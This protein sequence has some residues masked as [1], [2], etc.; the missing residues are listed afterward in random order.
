MD[1]LAEVQKDSRGFM[2][3]TT[4]TKLK[5]LSCRRE[6]HIWRI[7]AREKYTEFEDSN[8]EFG[9]GALV[10]FKVNAEG[11]LDGSIKTAHPEI[12]KILQHFSELKREN[13]SLAVR[14]EE[15]K[16]S[17]Q[18]EKDKLS[19]RESSIIN[20]YDKLGE[21]E[22]ELNQF[23]KEYSQLVGAVEQESKREAL[24]DS[25]I[26]KLA[27]EEA[28]IIQQLRDVE[29]NLKRG[30]CLEKAEVFE[31]EELID[32]LAEEIGLAD[33]DALMKLTN[34]KIASIEIA[35]SIKNKF[36][37]LEESNRLLSEVSMQQNYRSDIAS[38]LQERSELEKLENLPLEE[39]KE[40]TN[41]LEIELRRIAQ[42][43]R[44]QE[45]ELKG[46]AQDIALLQQQIAETRV[47]KLERRSLEEDL[48]EEEEAK[49][50]LEKTLEGQQ[51]SLEKRYAHFRK[52][53]YVLKRRSD[54]FDVEAEL[55]GMSAGLLREVLS[56]MQS[57]ADITK[58]KIEEEIERS[59]QDLADLQKIVEG[60]ALDFQ[61]VVTEIQQGLDS[62][63]QK[64][65]SAR[66]LSETSISKIQKTLEGLS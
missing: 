52:H 44:D 11:R 20:R 34:Q 61:E 3:G 47:S 39:L 54:I 63:Y 22:E 15:T 10:T 53:Y 23:A 9:H 65:N 1:F 38:V 35:A 17:L 40:V 58:A 7:L 50:L 57:T 4:K 28:S 24:V 49:E 42:F 29:H 46:K 51:R 30:K 32:L 5:L 2:G 12:L 48:A 56:D 26:K 18:K 19:N 45:E 6:D 43:V 66:D 41:N 64:S 31:L 62:I 13:A 33:V 8:G 36:E 60:N 55:Q 16:E 25:K 27:Q 37:E 59:Q 21:L 14:V